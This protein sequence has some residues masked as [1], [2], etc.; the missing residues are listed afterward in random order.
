MV[1]SVF[2]IS[3]FGIVLHPVGLALRVTIKSVSVLIRVHS[4]SQFLNLLPQDTKEHSFY[5]SFGHIATIGLVDLVEAVDQ[6]VAE[7]LVI[8]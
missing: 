2:G 8:A 1:Y 4:I 7:L 6:R 3:T 5:L